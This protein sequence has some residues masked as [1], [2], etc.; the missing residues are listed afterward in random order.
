LY[1]ATNPWIGKIGSRIVGGSSG[2]PIID[3]MKVSNKGHSPLSCLEKTLEWQHFAPTAPDTLSEYPFDKLDPLIITEY[4]NIYFVGNM[5]KYET[6]L[7]QGMEIND[8]TLII[9][10]C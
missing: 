5:E 4:P 2:Q 3:I 8:V 10:I 6:K 9:D 1:G 7:I